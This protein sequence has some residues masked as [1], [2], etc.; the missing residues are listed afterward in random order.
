[1]EIEFVD[2]GGLGA[3]ASGSRAGV[4]VRTD[5]KVQYESIDSSG[6]WRVDVWARRAMRSARF[7]SESGGGSSRRVGIWRHAPYVERSSCSTMQRAADD[8]CCVPM[9][10]DEKT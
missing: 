3:E 8:V 10:A 5:T 6:W 2:V 1:M 4:A 9:C 7:F